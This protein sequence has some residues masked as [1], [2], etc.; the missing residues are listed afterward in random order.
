[1]RGIIFVIKH[2]LCTTVLLFG[3]TALRADVFSFSYAGAGVSAGGTLTAKSPGLGVYTVTSISGLRNGTAISNSPLGG[4]AFTY[5][6]STHSLSS[7]GILFSAGGLLGTVS[8]VSGIG[9]G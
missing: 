5:N 3:A 6:A 7:A 2:L 8:Y 1:M 4:G 9:N